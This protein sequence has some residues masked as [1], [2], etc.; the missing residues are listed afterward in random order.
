MKRLSVHIRA[1]NVFIV[2][3]FVYCVLFSVLASVHGTEFMI[4]SDSPG[5]LQLA[6]N[7]SEHQV[8]SQS[9]QEP[10]EPDAFRT[11]LYPLFLSLIFLVAPGPWFVGIIQ[12]L[13]AAL[14]VSYTYKIGEQLSGKVAGTLAALVFGFDFFHLVEFQT[15]STNA[16]FVPFLVIATYYLCRYVKTRCTRLLLVS[17]VM[18]GLA[19]LTRPVGMY[20]LLGLPLVL[21]GIEVI[22]YRKV[23]VLVLK[24]ALVF[25]SVFFIVLSPWLVRNSVVFDEFSLTSIPPYN[26]YFWNL[27]SLHADYF[28]VAYQDVQEVLNADIQE[29]FP[30]L[31]QHDIRNFT[32]S[33]YYKDESL[34][35]IREHPA[36]YAREHMVGTVYFFLSNYYRKAVYIALGTN[37]SDI[38]VYNPV[39]MLKSGDFG[40]LFAL[41]ISKSGVPIMAAFVGFGISTVLVFF[42][43]ANVF[44]LRRSQIWEY[45]LV[46]YALITYMALITGPLGSGSYRYQVLPLIIILAVV[47]FARMWGKFVADH[48]RV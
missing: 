26:L 13:L 25:A 32:L 17:A 18:F 29:K 7:I 9:L 6:Q 10:L 34:R 33:E 15:V 28:G 1:R 42:M 35:I 2:A 31:Q 30:G 11:P 43:I 41:A 8:F 48:R 47:G 4:R 19:T 38:P 37:E 16:L 12:A 44:F 22:Q 3:A 36:A 46:L 5:Y 27:A 14:T 20:L 39:G 40:S 24:H 45:E 23:R 21:L